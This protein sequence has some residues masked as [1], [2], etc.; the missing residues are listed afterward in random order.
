MEKAASQSEAAFY[1]VVGAYR[2]TVM[3]FELVY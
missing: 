3:R 2:T 1:K